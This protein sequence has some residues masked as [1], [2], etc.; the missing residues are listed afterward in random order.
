[1]DFRA[2]RV[3]C[4]RDACRLSRRA[5]AAAVRM[6]Y[7]L[8]LLA[9]SRVREQNVGGGNKNVSAFLQ[10]V[11]YLH[12]RV[13]ISRWRSLPQHDNSTLVV[14]VVVD[15]DSR[16]RSCRRRKY[17]RRRRWRRVVRVDVA[18]RASC[19]SNELRNWRQRCAESRYT[20]PH[21][22]RQQCRVGRVGRLAPYARRF[23]ICASPPS[24]AQSTRTQRTRPAHTQRAPPSK[25]R[26][27]SRSSRRR[28]NKSRRA[29]AGGER[30]ER[31]APPLNTE[32]R[33]RLEQR[34]IVFAANRN[35]EAQNA[36]HRAS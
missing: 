27:E 18:A 33:D 31:N 14:V 15:I 10:C 12:Q 6:G 7:V 4:A 20:T 36:Y 5:A 34:R 35:K 23:A 13:R 24:Q 29:A 28:I 21:T 26:R 17:E 9:R 32:Q 2:A 16:R 30:R 3:D 11:A 8:F 22:R 1:M 19:R 25:R